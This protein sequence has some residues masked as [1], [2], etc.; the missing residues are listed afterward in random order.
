M[1][2]TA[3]A[4]VADSRRGMGIGLSLCK[5]IIVAHGGTIMVKDNKPQGTVFTFTIPAEE[6][7]FNE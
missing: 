7:V 3:N 6:L 2:Y 4:T 1:F 5:S